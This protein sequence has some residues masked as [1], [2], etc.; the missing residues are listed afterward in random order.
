SPA[1]TRERTRREGSIT[2]KKNRRRSCNKND[3][4][5][6]AVSEVLTFAGTAL[7]FVEM[8]C[9]EV[10]WLAIW[11]CSRAASINLPNCTPDGQAV[12][13]ARH[14]TQQYMCST[15]SSEIS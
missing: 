7:P 2:S 3:N 9:C 5:F 10:S 13:Q 14:P 15:K 6:G 12:S 1:N 4:C 11:I 8:S